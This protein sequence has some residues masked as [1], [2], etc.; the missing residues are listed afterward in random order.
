MIAVIEDNSLDRFLISKSIGDVD[1]FMNVS[2]FEDQ[3]YEL[4]FTDLSLPETWGDETVVELRKK[5]KAPIIVLT[6]LGGRYLSGK[7][8]KSLIDAGASEVFSKEILE[9]CE[10]LKN[11]VKIALS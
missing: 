9:D 11:I 2:D 1:Y 6:G 3:G 4:V 8:M 5:T 10:Y 7:A